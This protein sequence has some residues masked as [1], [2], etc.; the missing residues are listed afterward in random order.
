LK[1]DG[2][3]LYRTAAKKMLDELSGSEL[4]APAPNK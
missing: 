2:L 4:P 3:F 1:H